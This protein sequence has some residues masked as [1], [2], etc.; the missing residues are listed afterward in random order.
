MLLIISYPLWRQLKLIPVLISLTTIVQCVSCIHKADYVYTI[1]YIKLATRKQ[2]QKHHGKREMTFNL[3]TAILSQML[4]RLDMFVCRKWQ[5]FTGIHVIAFSTMALLWY[6]P[7]K[8]TWGSNWKQYSLCSYLNKFLERQ[9]RVCVALTTVV[10][11]QPLVPPTELYWLNGKKYTYTP[12]LSR[13][14][15]ERSYWISKLVYVMYWQHAAR[16]RQFKIETDGGTNR[17]CG[18]VRQMER[19]LLDPESEK[20][21][22]WY[23]YGNENKCDKHCNLSFRF[24]VGE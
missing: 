8:P 15:N 21:I 4:P 14:K 24:C 2:Q 19:I 22:N 17:I 3:S 20:L 13:W 9:V 16:L 6:T 18:R 11:K 23:R 7:S 1:S 10:G 5:S 12:I